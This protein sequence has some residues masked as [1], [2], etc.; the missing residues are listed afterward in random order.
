MKIEREEI[1]NSGRFYINENNET[2]AEMLYTRLNANT[3]L[4]T[5][6]EVDESLEGKGIGKQLVAAA[7]E[8]ARNNSFTIKVTCPFAKKVLDRTKE[9]AD[10]Y[11]S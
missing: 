5:H 10:V 6:T 11:T 8:Y 2:L 1:E 4:I 3:F 7:V 9:Y